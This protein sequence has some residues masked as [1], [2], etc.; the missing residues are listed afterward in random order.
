[1][2]HEALK[3][4]YKYGFVTEIETEEFPLGLSEDIVRLISA[5]KE[6][7][8]WMLEFRLKAYRRWREMPYPKW[9]HIE[10][11]AIDFQKIYHYAAPKKKMPQSNSLD[12]V[13]PALLSTFD[14]LGIPLAEQKRLTG[15]AVDA[16]FDSV[17]VGTTHQ[18]ELEKV[19]V[20]FCS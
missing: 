14:R 11:E 2:D 18:E 15:V 16:V 19:G 9:A 3:G 20:I 4:E 5:K 7:P 13:D 17:S 1:R 8:E 10:Y 12:E 6:E